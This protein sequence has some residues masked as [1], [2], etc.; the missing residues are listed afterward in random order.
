MEPIMDRRTILQSALGF[1]AGVAT[2]GMMAKA[3]EAIEAV[4]LAVPSSPFPMPRGEWIE[5]AQIWE[6]NGEDW[7]HRQRWHGDDDDDDEED[8]H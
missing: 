1:A 4:T 5:Q 6:D 7:R 8:D 3:A 2:I